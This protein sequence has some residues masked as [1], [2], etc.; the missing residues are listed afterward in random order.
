MQTSPIGQ[1]KRFN[2]LDPKDNL[3]QNNFGMIVA[4][5]GTNLPP[6]TAILLKV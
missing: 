6:K 2:S 3:K 1:T 5:F 4:E